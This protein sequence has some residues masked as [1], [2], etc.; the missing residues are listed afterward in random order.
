MKDLI[1][2]LLGIRKKRKSLPLSPPPRTGTVIVRKNIKAV[3]PKRISSE[4]W[5]W[6]MLSGWRVN[7]VRND[8]RNYAILPDDA[9]D[10]LI[11][12]SEDQRS[13]IH[14]SLLRS[15]ESQH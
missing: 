13:N 6:M 15:A 12:A 1:R 5:D 7:P 14:N 11:R 10:Q 8:R 4:L 2:T 3:V 9:L